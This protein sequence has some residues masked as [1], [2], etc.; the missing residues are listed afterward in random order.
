MF[1]LQVSF[2]IQWFLYGVIQLRDYFSDVE[3]VVTAKLATWKVQHLG[4]WSDLVEVAAPSAPVLSASELMDLEDEA[5][6][7]RFREARAKLAQDTADMCQFNA[8]AEE[9]KRRAHVVTVL[10]EKAQVQQG[11][12]LLVEHA[13]SLF[14]CLFV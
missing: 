2:Q 8:K 6:A 9:N 14:V 7:A 4:V 10:H 5:Q 3:A 12:E 11:K 1:S 13:S